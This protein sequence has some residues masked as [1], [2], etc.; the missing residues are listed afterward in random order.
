MKNNKPAVLVTGATGFVGANLVE[1]LVKR[2]CAVSCLVR[3]TSDTRF[4]QTLPVQLIVADLENAAGVRDALKGVEVAYHVAGAIKGASR[5]AFMKANKIGTR[6]LLETLAE[7]S[8]IR[9]FVHVS[10][11]A[12]AGP[13]PDG[14]ALTE[15]QPPHPISWYG[16]SKLES[17]NEVLNYAKAFSVVILRPSAV[18]GPNDRETLLLFRMIHR[19]C[20]FT[21]GR[22]TRHFSLIHV[23]DL[24]DA[25][26]LA[27]EG[28]TPSGEAFFVSRQE[29]YTWDEVGRTIARE[30]GK[31]YRRIAFPP[32]MAK[33]A[34]LAG[35]VWM[36]L[37]GRPATVSSQKVNEL[38]H[39]S[40]VCSPAKAQ[41]FLDFCPQI[42]LDSGIRGTVQWYRAKGWI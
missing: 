30:L 35:D 42:D 19:G 33:A 5:D 9:R 34:G 15:E 27:G 24:S 1:K 32:G 11:L 28:S 25:L 7:H 38:L 41:R 37:S 13:S 26:I 18:Y 2:G 20:L 8:S 16:E 3:G 22:F 39:P 17:E 4:L 36:K 10:S 12:A 23:G 29:I 40:W 21:P 14:T 31:K 6:R